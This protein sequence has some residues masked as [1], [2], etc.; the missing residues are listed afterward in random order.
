MLHCEHLAGA[1][2]SGLHFV[3]DEQDAEFARQFTESREEARWRHNV[4]TLTEYWLNNNGGNILC[5]REC[6]QGEIPL[7][8]PAAAASGAGAAT[9]WCARVARRNR[10]AVAGG[11]CGA[12]DRPWERL[13]VA[14]VDVLCG[15]HRHGLRGTAVISAAEDKDHAALRCATRQLHRRLNRLTPGV[16]EEDAPRSTREHF[17]ETFVESQSWLVVDDVLLAV[18]QLRRLFGDRRRDLRVRVTSVHHADP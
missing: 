9:S 8:F 10:C 5:A 6:V 4:A 3:G 12:V 7:L 14:A 15:G 1:A 13:K 11:K 17:A 16:G 18:N 2:E